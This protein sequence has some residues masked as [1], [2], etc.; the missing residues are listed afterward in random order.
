MKFPFDLSTYIQQCKDLVDQAAHWAERARHWARIA[1]TG[2]G[3]REI[4][5]GTTEVTVG[6]DDDAFTYFMV[7]D[8]L[9][10]VTFFLVSDPVPGTT[11]QIQNF[12]FGV[13]QVQE[14]DDGIIQTPGTTQLRG[15]GSVVSLT[16]IRAKSEAAEA[17]WTLTGDTV[18]L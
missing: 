11:F 16:A 4:E 1:L 10:T 14:L 9:N 5:A 3:L 8:D 6:T 17:L 18:P 7:N 12:G 15:N 2:V 13:V